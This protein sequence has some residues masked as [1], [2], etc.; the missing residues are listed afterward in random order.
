MQT[1]NDD[2]KILDERVLVPKQLILKY[3][4]SPILIFISF[5]LWVFMRGLYSP[6]KAQSPTV[7]NLGFPFWLIILSMIIFFIL[8]Y[9]IIYFW[10]YKGYDKRTYISFFRNHIRIETFEYA[11]NFK[12]SNAQRIVFR[13]LPFMHLFFKTYAVYKLKIIY[14]GD[15][16]VFHIPIK[17]PDKEKK[18]KSLL[19]L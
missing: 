5:V 11:I 19:K 13:E 8:I 7:I 15:K 14:E 9:L 17:E 2:E 6:N 16:Y 10:R 3:I 4:L 12:I 1:E 18:L